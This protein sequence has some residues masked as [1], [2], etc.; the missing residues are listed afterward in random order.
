[1]GEAIGAMLASAAGIAIGPRPLIA[2][3]LMLA[4]PRGRP[5][6]LALTAG[7]A[8]ALG[9]IVAV[10]VTLGS[11]LDPDRDEPTWSAWLKLALGAVLLLLALRQWRDRP[12]EGHVTAPPGWMRSVHRF[13]A[14]RSA[15][16][17]AAL[18]AASPKNVVL[19]VGGAAS[20]A[21]SPTSGAGRAVAAALMVL[22]ASL[23]TLLPLAV[24]VMARD[25]AARTLGEWK[26]WAAAHHAAITTTVVAVLGTTY[27]GDALT[28]LA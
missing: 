4:T 23:C 7:R 13:T 26:A 19:A 15:R 22:I 6:A 24:H 20:I 28:V 21:A 25:S 17:G 14:G 2:A 8:A 3:I 10:V 11:G 1:M 16:L 27:L 5:N 18:A 12:R 9:A